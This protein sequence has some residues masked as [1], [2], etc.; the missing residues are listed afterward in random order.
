MKFVRQCWLRILFSIVLL[1]F[2]TAVGV[3][4]W[5]GSQIASPPRRELLDYHREY[6]S[7]PAAHGLVLDRFTASDGT[8]CLMCAP[9]PSGNLGDRGIKIRQQLAERGHTLEPAGRIVGT[10]VLVHGRKGRKEDYLPIAE[11]LCAAGF[12]CVIPDMPA[13]GDHPAR[14]ITYGVREAGLPYRVLHEAAARFSFDPKPA[15]LLGMSMGG[16]VSVHAAAMPGAPW[17]AL[18]VI[19][20]FDSFPKVIEGQASYYIGSTLGPFW[21]KGTDI[22]YQSKT[23]IHLAK[24]QPHRHAASITIPTLIAHGTADPV[25]SMNCGQCLFEALP[26]TTT[27]RWIEIP[28]AAHDNVLITSYP[29][30]ADLAEWMLR[31]VTGR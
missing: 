22:V 30:Y 18:A 10:L 20:S 2:L 24:I 25:S 6:L 14:T 4:F 16:S 29:I 28:G 27:K 12:R 5:A 3:I 21:A 1:I 26:A 11:R 9:D 31:H 15:G 19:S 7:N 23:G 8:P 17:K 13:H